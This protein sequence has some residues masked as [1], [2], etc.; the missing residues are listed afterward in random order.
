MKGKRGTK[1][2]NFTEIYA[3]YLPK[4]S[5]KDMKEQ[6]GSHHTFFKNCHPTGALMNQQAIV[7]VKLELKILADVTSR[8]L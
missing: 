1:H 4:L 7:F 3:T 5:V 8:S 6:L 2:H